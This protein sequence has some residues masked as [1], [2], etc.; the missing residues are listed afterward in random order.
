[1]VEWKQGFLYNNPPRQVNLTLL[2]ENLCKFTE[3]IPIFWDVERSDDYLSK[4]LGKER[5]LGMEKTL[6]AAIGICV[7]KENYIFLL[8]H[9]MLSCLGCKYNKKC[10]LVEAGTLYCLN[11]QQLVS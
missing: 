7:G 1:M 5:Y 9:L 4:M 8:L 10:R 3:D 6:P 2:V 11:L